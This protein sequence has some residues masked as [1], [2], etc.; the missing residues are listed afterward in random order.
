MR[1]LLGSFFT[2]VLTAL[3]AILPGLILFLILDYFYDLAHRLY[4]YLLAITKSDLLT[5]GFIA[6]SLLLLYLIGYE[7]R[8]K[9]KNFLIVLFEKIVEKIPVIEKIYKTIRYIITI[10]SGTRKEYLGVVKVSLGKYR[11]YGFVTSRDE[12]E[13]GRIELAIFCPTTP[14]P[15]SGFVIFAFDE[16]VEHTDMEVTDAMQRIISLGANRVE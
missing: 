4:D 1:K 8:K 11:V 3:L 7:I 9:G 15:T 16:D 5:V 2:N 14:N 10:F 12:T 6:G 13:E